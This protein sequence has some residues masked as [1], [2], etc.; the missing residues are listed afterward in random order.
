VAGQPDA[1]GMPAPVN[2]LDIDMPVVLASARAG[3]RIKAK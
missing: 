3:R 2:L 1:S